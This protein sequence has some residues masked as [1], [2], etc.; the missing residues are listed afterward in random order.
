MTHQFAA[1]LAQQTPQLFRELHRR[2][3]DVEIVDRRV[4]VQNDCNALRAE[5]RGEREV[6]NDRDSSAHR[7]REIIGFENK[8]GMGIGRDEKP[9]ALW[10]S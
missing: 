10:V 1:S 3:A 2:S 6:R 9:A 8:P 5:T 7:I 4:L